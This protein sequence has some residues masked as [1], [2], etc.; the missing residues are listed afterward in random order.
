[1]HGGMQIPAKYQENFSY[2]PSLFLF[3]LLFV[4]ARETD[5]SN[6]ILPPSSRFVQVPIIRHLTFS[7]ASV[8]DNTLKYIQ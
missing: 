2:K 3:S 6:R 7:L 5:D 1:M 8:I 4:Y